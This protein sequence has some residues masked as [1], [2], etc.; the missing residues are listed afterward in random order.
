MNAAG[1]NPTERAEG[2]FVAFEGGEAAG[3]TTQIDA[4]DRWLV[5]QGHRVVRTREPGGTEIGERIRSLVLEHGQ[6]EVDPRTEA[7]L[8]AA[9]R[10]AHVQQVIRPALVSDAVVLC[11]R[12]IDSSL[13]YQGAGRGLGVEVVAEINAWATEGLQPDLTVLL[14]LDPQVSRRRRA[15]RD[16]GAAGDRIESADDDFHQSLR[17][18]FLD[19]AKGSPQRYL[20]LDASGSPQDIHRRVVERLNPLLS[21]G[22]AIAG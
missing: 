17:Q 13:A 20:V 6:G 8:F 19:R 7:L 2:L 3:K 11:D 5:N 1:P 9:S 21:A 15:T 14:D 4:L 10:A 16:G 18:A 22:K 12:Y